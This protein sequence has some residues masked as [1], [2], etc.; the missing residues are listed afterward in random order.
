[1][2]RRRGTGKALLAWAARATWRA[3]Q[4]WIKLWRC[5]S[6]PEEHH[7]HRQRGRLRDLR[8][9][10]RPG[11]RAR[12]HAVQFAGHHIAHVGCPGRAVSPALSPRALRPARPRP[13]RRAERPYTME[14][15]GQDGLA[16]LDALGIER[17][18]WCGLSMGGM[19]GQWLGAKAPERI[20]R[21]VLTNT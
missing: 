5:G 10:R 11:K 21:L 6:S 18:N 16:V 3:A 9:S 20:E 15:L 13:L 14:C 19:V 1:I 17:V 7:A 8:R 4:R 2:K 12:A